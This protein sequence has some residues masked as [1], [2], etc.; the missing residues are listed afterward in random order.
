M[1]SSGGAIWTET[2]TCA[3]DAVDR[4]RIPAANDSERMKRLRNYFPSA[5]PLSALLRRYSQAEGQTAM[6]ERAK[7][8][9]LANLLDPRAETSLKAWSVPGVADRR[10]LRSRGCDYCVGVL[11][12]LPPN[13]HQRIVFAQGAGRPYWC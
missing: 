6:F 9:A 5:D 11:S 13:G 3:K 10:R 1:S 8:I 4:S 2:P 7:E 12:A